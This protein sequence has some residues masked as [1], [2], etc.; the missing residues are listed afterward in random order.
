MPK[1]KENLI[2][3][4]WD[5]AVLL[6]LAAVGIYVFLGRVI[7]SPIQAGSQMGVQQTPA[8]LVDNL[9]DETEILRRKMNE[10]AASEAQAPSYVGIIQKR[11]NESPAVSLPR[12]SLTL[13][14]PGVEKLPGVV[15]LA[16]PPVLAPVNVRGRAGIGL[17]TTVSET[18]RSVSQTTAGAS[19][20]E[21]CWI[22]VAAEFPFHQ[23]YLGFAGLDPKVEQESRLPVNEHR[24]VF[25]RVDMQRQELLADGSW[26][27]AKDI[28]PYDIF[29]GNLPNTVASLSQLYSLT[30]DDEQSDNAYV[31]KDWLTRAGFQE[32]IVR[33]EFFQLSGFEQ[34]YWPESLVNANDDREVF[35]TAAG[36]LPQ[37]D[38]APKYRA[39]STVRADILTTDRTRAN[40]PAAPRDLAGGLMPPDGMPVQ[41]RMETSA[42]AGSTVTS[43]G[44]AGRAQRIEIP[45]D[46][47]QQTIPLWAHDSSVVPGRTYRYRM[48]VLLFNPLCGHQQATS[49]KVRKSAWLEGPWSGWS[50]SVEAM[51]KRL[52]YFTGVSPA[53]GGKPPRARVTVYAWQA[54]WW[55]EHLFFYSDAGSIIGG[56]MEVPDF[57]LEEMAVS[58]RGDTSRRGTR[59]DSPGPRRARLTVD[60]STGWSIVD[61][62][63]EMQLEQPSDR[64]STKIETI[65]TAELVVT[66]QATQEIEKRYAVID[67]DNLHR[68]ELEQTVARQEAAFR[69]MQRGLD[70]RSRPSRTD[71]SRTPPPIMPPGGGLIPGRP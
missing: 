27:E 15:Y 54:G 69:E 42:R 37:K 58:G 46:Y 50:E 62:S 51:Q 41:L 43:R 5:K 59:A 18:S 14:G 39:V 71:R 20:R 23:Q 60:F 56:P 48:R 32:F 53:R 16:R 10:P 52:F 29:R 1:G 8:N 67:S 44:R 28:N 57:V 11:L 63:P 55:Y 45:Q 66:E 25:A 68:Q 30:S 13:Q 33:P 40:S 3:Q 26:S 7:S 36:E 6:I 22:T 17:I 49:S 65:T 35:K 21:A 61:F 47:R 34:W 19:G 64:E 9:C 4:Y 70:D 31:L 2:F 38:E 12:N 24:F